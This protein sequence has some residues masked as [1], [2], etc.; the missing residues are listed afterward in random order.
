MVLNHKKL[1]SGDR[2][3]CSLTTGNE[4][5][6]GSGGRN[7]ERMAVGGRDGESRGSFTEENTQVELLSDQK[8]PALD[9]A[10]SICKY[11]HAE[12]KLQIQDILG[13][14]MRLGAVSLP[15]MQA[16][17]PGFQTFG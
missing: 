12:V 6:G 13:Y 15:R 14:R 8:V 7:K 10:L 5:Q 11:T 16:Q 1:E 9:I 2:R 3:F 17:P 4:G